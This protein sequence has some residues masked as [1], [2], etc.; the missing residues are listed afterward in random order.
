MRLG[1]GNKLKRILLGCFFLVCTCVLSSF[2]FW[3]RGDLHTGLTIHSASAH[4][5]FWH[6]AL[7]E[8]LQKHIPPDNPLLSGVKL[9]GYHY[10]NDILWVIVHLLTGISLTVLYLQIAPVVLA[11]LFV[12]STYLLF[13][14]IFPKQTEVLIATSFLILSSGFAYVVPF[15]FHRSLG[16]QS[17]FWLDQSVRYG[18]NQQFLSSLSVINI[19]FLILLR[20]FKKQWWGAG[21]LLGLL[22]GI[23]I[24]AFLLLFPPLGIL[25]VYFYFK[26]KNWRWSGMCLIGG[27]VATLMIAVVGTSN[28]FPFFWQPGWFFK[29]M[30]ESGERLN[31]PRWELMDQHYL[32]DHSW[33]KLIPLWGAAIVL[34]FVGNFGVKILGLGFFFV[35]KKIH[36][37]KK[38]LFFLLGCILLESFLVPSLFLQ[39]GVVWN[40]IQFLQ[41]AQLPLTCFLV[42]TIATRFPKKKNVLY[43]MMLLISLPTTVQTVVKDVDKKWYYSYPPAITEKIGKLRKLPENQMIIAGSLLNVYSIVPA[44]SGHPVFW[45][46]STILSILG[47]DHPERAAYIS[48]LERGLTNCPVGEIFLTE[49]K[50]QVVVLSC[51]LVVPASQKVVTNF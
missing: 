5:A 7:M 38:E 17:V 15:I 25:A 30:F 43:A 33:L 1:M 19:F 18:M 40:T 37:Y 41:Y 47:E 50:S 11:L 48:A 12:L 45:A 46:D 4:D 13:K 8:A 10:V 29:T 36:F 34:F 39:T 3:Q 14:H 6:L 51:P 22:A 27:I 26:E 2:T 32:R 16:D 24:Y 20:H 42:W 28:G 31:F 44:L 23:K 49:V 9:H 35:S 21:I